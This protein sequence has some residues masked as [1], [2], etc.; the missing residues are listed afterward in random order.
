MRSGH[1]QQ[2]LLAAAV[3]AGG[4]AGCKAEL[5]TD[6]DNHLTVDGGPGT[7]ATSMD[8][9]ADAIL[10][11]P[12]APPDARLCDGGD[13]HKLSADGTC[14]LRFDTA[15]DRAGAAAVCAANNTTLAI[16]K[17][18]ADQAAAISLGST[19]DL[20]I[21]ATDLVTEGTFL[22]PDTTPVV[23]SAW[24]PG[25]PNDGGTDGED[26]SVLAFTAQ[27]AGKWDDRNCITA[28]YTALCSFK[29]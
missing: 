19:V 10:D 23:F 14:Y 9:G 15:H 4:T 6:P 26:C 8:G 1:I 29:P 3:V 7:D 17:S 24:S 13:A 16:I 28:A 20:W 22:W 27:R 5:G 11:A 18:A 12:D 21:G 25:E 2:V